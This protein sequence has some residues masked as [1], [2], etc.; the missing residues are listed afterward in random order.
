LLRTKD[1]YA[2]RAILPRPEGRGLPRYLVKAGETL[3]QLDTGRPVSRFAREAV[4]LDG[5][6][7]GKYWSSTEEMAAR[8]FQSWLEDRLASENRRNDYL[9]VYA[10]NKFHID[11]DSGKVVTLR[12]ALLPVNMRTLRLP[13]PCRSSM[14]DALDCPAS[15][16]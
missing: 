4:V 1:G 14:L 3:A 8:A 12:Q 2:V 7:E 11:P 6:V 5:G 9:S 10:D 13:L 15:N 16:G